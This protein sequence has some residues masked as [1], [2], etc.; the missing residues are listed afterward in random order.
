MYTSDLVEF[1]WRFSTHATGKSLPNRKVLVI[2]LMLS[3]RHWRP[4]TWA[5]IPI[6]GYKRIQGRR[7]SERTTISGKIDVPSFSGTQTTLF[8][9]CMFFLSPGKRVVFLHSIHSSNLMK[10]EGVLQVEKSVWSAVAR[11]CRKLYSC[12]ISLLWMTQLAR[13]NCNEN[14]I[15]TLDVQWIEFE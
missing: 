2:T 5:E 6:A 12:S 3:A 7:E 1:N 10:I 8:R 13:G 4:G 15:M 11:C 9:R 14:Q